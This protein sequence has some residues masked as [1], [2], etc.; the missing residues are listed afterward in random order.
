MKKTNK[1]E[2]RKWSWTIWVVIALGVIVFA[3]PISEKLKIILSIPLYAMFLFVY[4][5]FMRKKGSS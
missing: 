5:K 4:Y 1:I 3:L 2:M